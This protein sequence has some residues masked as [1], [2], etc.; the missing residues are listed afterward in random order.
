MDTTPPH[1]TT[2]H[3]PTHNQH[4]LNSLQLLL[5]S[6]P[7]LP[8]SYQHTKADKRASSNPS[9]NNFIQKTFMILEE[10]KF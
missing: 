5:P 3:S 2:N 9:V 4:P 8:S 6:Q 1:A 10:K 7:H